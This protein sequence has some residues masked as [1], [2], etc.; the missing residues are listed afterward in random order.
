MVHE[1][2]PVRPH[3][4][5]IPWPWHAVL[6]VLLACGLY[7][8]GG[9]APSLAPGPRTV[10]VTGLLIVI[11]VVDVTT[12]SRYIAQGLERSM[13]QLAAL[14]L[15]VLG[16]GAVFL[17]TPPQLPAPAHAVIAAACGALV[18]VVLRWEQGV[19]TRRA[20]AIAER[21]RDSPPPGP[22]GD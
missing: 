12:R 3:P 8:A 9:G 16:I 2:S 17:L 14:G 10:I 19:Q 18:F 22:D 11:V 1:Y 13:V 4:R 7:I 5:S 15:T 20:Q 21:L 6:G